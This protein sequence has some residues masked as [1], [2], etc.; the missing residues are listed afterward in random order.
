MNLRTIMI[1][2]EFEN[3]NVINEI[4]NK[5]DPLTDLVLPHITLVFPFDSELTNKE[6]NLYLKE[7]LIDIHQFKVELKGFGEHEE[8]IIVIEHELN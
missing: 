3:M 1:F 6:L 5:Y 4:R 7:S 2:P 8:S